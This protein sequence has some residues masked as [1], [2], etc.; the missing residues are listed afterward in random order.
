MRLL[1][2]K[3][4]HLANVMMNLA[5]Q[6]D[7]EDN[8]IKSLKDPN[9]LEKFIVQLEVSEGILTTALAELRLV[10]INKYLKIKEKEKTAMNENYGEIRIGKDCLNSEMKQ[11]RIT[12]KAFMLE[13]G[14]PQTDQEILNEAENAAHDTNYKGPMNPGPLT[15]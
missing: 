1:A 4:M 7:T 10:A 5:S 15:D 3:F 6:L 9:D 2:D 8:V 11:A 13:K 12:H 14:R